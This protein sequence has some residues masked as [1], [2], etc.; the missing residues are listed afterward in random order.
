MKLS[1]DFVL[2]PSPHR[3][4]NE[5]YPMRVAGA[6]PVAAVDPTRAE[7]GALRQSRE[8]KDHRRPRAFLRR[9]PLRQRRWWRRPSIPVTPQR[10][11]GSELDSTRQKPAAVGQQRRH[12]SALDYGSQSLRQKRHDRSSANKKILRRKMRARKTSLVN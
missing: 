5:T 2:R 10:R 6:V 9:R 11:A 8:A 4:N 3:V 12:R 1:Q 7:P